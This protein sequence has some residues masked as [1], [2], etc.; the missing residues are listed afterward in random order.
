MLMLSTFV[1]RLYL[2]LHFCCTWHDVLMCYFT[3]ANSK[4][5]VRAICDKLSLSFPT[6]TAWSYKQGGNIPYYPL[7]IYKAYEELFPKKCKSWRWLYMGTGWPVAPPFIHLANYG[8]KYCFVL[9][10]C[11]A[12]EFRSQYFSERLLRSWSVPKWRVT[13]TVHSK[14]SETF[15]IRLI[16]QSQ[17]SQWGK[18]CRKANG[19]DWAK[20]LKSFDGK[21]RTNHVHSLFD[22]FCP[23]GNFGI[24]K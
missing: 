18:I 14:F 16:Y 2:L 22:K 3:V 24:D 6:C 10:F 5:E 20:D 12:D 11:D 9:I 13:M 19:R 21:K 1:I 15:F 17:N 7:P 4:K 23:I 8:Q